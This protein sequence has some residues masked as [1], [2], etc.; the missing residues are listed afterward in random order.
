LLGD[1]T[2][3]S[4]YKAA[5]VRNISGIKKGRIKAGKSMVVLQVDFGYFAKH[6]KSPV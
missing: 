3:P 1:G 5:K 6:F 2:R 4:V